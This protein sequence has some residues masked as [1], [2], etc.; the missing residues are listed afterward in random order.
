MMKVEDYITIAVPIYNSERYL[1]FC[2]ESIIN[3]SY[4]KLDI[5]LIN[6]GSTDNSLQICKEYA[7][8]DKRIRIITQENKGT[9]Y[10][11]NVAIHYSKG[12]YITF[13][14]SDDFI[15]CEY[16]KKLYLM[17]KEYNTDISIVNF[18]DTKDYSFRNN[19]EFNKK[20][21]LSNI[22]VL[23]KLLEGNN[24]LYVLPCCKLY[25]K[26]LFTDN[27]IVYPENII[28][29]DEAVTYKL[30]Y[31]AKNIVISS[32]RLYYYVFNKEGKSKRRFD[33]FN[34]YNLKA[35][36][37]R[38]LF[39]KNHNEDLLTVKSLIAYS[40][41]L[42]DYYCS[43]KKYLKGRKDYTKIISQ[44]FAETKSYSKLVIKNYSC[45]LRG[46]IKLKIYISSISPN[47]YYYIFLVKNTTMNK[48][49]CFLNRMSFIRKNNHK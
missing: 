4:E 15:D 2:I 6:D 26:I 43:S 7:E 12:K 5:L 35:Y 18:Y 32:E 42:I 16:V 33:I 24:C 25:K 30:I 19:G 8:K 23:K 10:S 47:I 37:E 27:H 11:R 39:F 14:D 20:S 9:G 40:R 21:L 45:D 34:L 28:A 36:K 49:F 3:Q 41:I 38:Y 29:E 48:L 22:D 13:V 31:Y 1:K 46:L 17:C 44:L